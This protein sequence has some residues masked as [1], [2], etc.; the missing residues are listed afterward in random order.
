[1]EIMKLTTDDLILL[2]VFSQLA[3][4]AIKAEEAILKH[5]ENAF[6]INKQ[7]IHVYHT[8]SLGEYYGD[9]YLTINGIF[10]YHDNWWGGR[11]YQFSCDAESIYRM[12]RSCYLRKNNHEKMDTEKFDCQIDHIDDYFRGF[13]AS[14]EEKDEL[15]KKLW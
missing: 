5:F 1:M 4:E 9:G 11:D 15:H 3:D 12:L 2:N 6:G 14:L 8:E 10:R 13:I 7:E